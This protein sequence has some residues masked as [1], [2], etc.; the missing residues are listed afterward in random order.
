M[1][2]CWDCIS[3]K[4]NNNKDVVLRRK[5]AVSVA[6]K[7]Q[8]LR[9]SYQSRTSS[10]DC[11]WNVLINLVFLIHHSRMDFLR[12]FVRVHNSFLLRAGRSGDRILLGW[13]FP[14]VQTGPETHPASCTLGT[15]SFPGINYGRGVL[16]TTHPLLVSWFWKNRAI[17]LPTIWATV[18]PV[19]GT[20]YIIL[21]FCLAQ[22]FCIPV[23]FLHKEPS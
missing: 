18:G 12:H 6:N 8:D 20:L 14:P 23:R 10:S 2:L 11:V 13:D 4:N 3:D 16:L 15:V 5:T 19:T 17:P 9:I 1:V 21:F 7:G 22:S